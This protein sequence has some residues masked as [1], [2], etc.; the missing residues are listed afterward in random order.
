MYLFSLVNSLNDYTGGI[1][2]GEYYKNQELFMPKVARAYPAVPPLLEKYS[3][4]IARIN[5]GS[6]DFGES[7]AIR[8]AYNALRFNL[9]E[10]PDNCSALILSRIQGFVTSM[11]FPHVVAFAEEACQLWGY[12]FLFISLS[13]PELEKYVTPLGFKPITSGINPHSEKI[14][15]YYVKIID[16]SKYMGL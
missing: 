6:D 10:F 1:D 4:M 2:T 5:N 12:G 9:C 7:T 8:F 14:N 16:C 11:A 13:E 15:T 3:M